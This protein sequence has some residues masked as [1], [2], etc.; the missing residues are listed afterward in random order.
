M[1]YGVMQNKT[2]SSIIFPAQEFVVHRIW[3]QAS[4]LI[5]KE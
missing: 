4:A 3:K 2:I 5:L 1:N